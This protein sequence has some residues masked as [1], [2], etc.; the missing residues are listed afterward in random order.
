MIRTSKTNERHQL[1]N[2]KEPKQPSRINEKTYLS[3]KKTRDKGKILQS[4]KGVGKW[5]IIF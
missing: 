1:K 2:P 5:G 4:A 3:K